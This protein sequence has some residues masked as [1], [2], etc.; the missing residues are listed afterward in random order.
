MINVGF[1]GTKG[2]YSEMALY[3]FFDRKLVNAIGVDHSHD[4]CEAIDSNTIQYAIL[5][6]EPK[7]THSRLL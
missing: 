7:S 6:V 4:I 5:P 1:Q 3:K 2:S